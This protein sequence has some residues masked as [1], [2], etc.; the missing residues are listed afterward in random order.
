MGTMIRLIPAESMQEATAPSPLTGFPSAPVHAIPCD[1]LSR[2]YAEHL[3]VDIRPYLGDLKEIQ[4][5]RCPKS[6]FRFYHPNGVVGDDAFYR[7][8]AMHPWYYQGEKWEFTEAI[9]LLP[10]EGQVLEVG[11][12][13]GD[14][15]QACLSAHPR[16]RVTGLE[17]NREAA[18]VARRMGL[19]VRQETLEGHAKS[20][21]QSYDAVCAF[22]VLEHISEPL[23]FLRACLRVLKPGGLL[24]VAVP[25]CTEQQPPS[26]LAVP[27]DPLNMPPHHQGLWDVPSLVFLSQILPM[28]LCH[29]GWEKVGKEA[30]LDNYVRLVRVGLKNQFGG[31]FGRLLHSLGRPYLRACLR[32]LAPFLP[33]HSLFV[34]F[35]HEESGQ[36]SPEP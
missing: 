27:E 12:G 20:H 11:P 2:I 35:Q 4:L 34:V 23:P 22:Q 13:K 16:L 31:L 5:R 7:A 25:D 24:M 19:D 30:Q 6:G 10:S 21:G 3:Q 17:L 32:S 29:L 9:R 26:P 33:G 28:R 18:E 1:D 36:A 8:L 15:I 14:F